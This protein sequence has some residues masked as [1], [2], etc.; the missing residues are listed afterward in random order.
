[1]CLNETYS[2]VHESKYLSDSFHIRNGLRQG[3]ALSQLLFNLALEYAI[4]NVQEKQVGL[5]L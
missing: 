4:R 1:M 3:D 5:K 2:E